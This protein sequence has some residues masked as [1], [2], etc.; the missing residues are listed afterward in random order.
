[1]PLRV[2]GSA[3]EFGQIGEEIVG[4]PESHAGCVET[5]DR[6]RPREQDVVQMG[7]GLNH[8]EADEGAGVERLV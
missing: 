5:G 6:A 3:D 8:P 2:V 1:M 7:C 4:G